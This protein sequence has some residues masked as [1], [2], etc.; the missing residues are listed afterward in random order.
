MVLTF[1]LLVGEKQVISS[2]SI[3]EL[4]HRRRSAG[5]THPFFWN[6]S[7]ALDILM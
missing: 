5:P 2:L 3:S 4:G 6:P 1:M 7:G